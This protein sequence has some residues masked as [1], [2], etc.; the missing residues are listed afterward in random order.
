MCC[1]SLA[2]DHTVKRGHWSAM[3]V[4]GSARLH[5]VIQGPELGSS[6]TCMCCL[7]CAAI[8]LVCAGRGAFSQ[9][10]ISTDNDRRQH[11]RPE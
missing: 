11:Q 7:S 8:E 1:T 10:D 4:S 9:Q 5:D 6:C 2:G 3:M